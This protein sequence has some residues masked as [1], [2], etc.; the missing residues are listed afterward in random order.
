MLNKV[1]VTG[2]QGFCGRYICA[3]IL[4]YLPDIEILGIGRSEELEHVFTH[5]I[6]VR[7]QE[8]TP[9]PLTEDLLESLNN[10]RYRYCK[11]D[12]SDIPAITEVLTTFKPDIIIHLAS[13]LKGDSIRKLYSTN[14]DGTTTLLNLYKQ[15]LNSFSI[16]ALSSG[17]VY[18]FP[19]K[20]E[21]LPFTETSDMNP[22][23]SYQ[24]AKS[25]EE[26]IV[27][28][29]TNLSGIPCAILRVFNIV[30]PGQDERHVLGRFT[31]L[32]SRIKNGWM[33]PTIET[34]GLNSSRDFID[35]RDIA[36]AITHL[37]KTNQINGTYNVCS[38]KPLVITDLLS[39]CIKLT[40]KTAECSITFTSPSSSLLKNPIEIDHHVGCNRKIKNT[41]V[42]IDHDITSSIKDMVC[43]YDCVN[44]KN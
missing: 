42:E 4:K 38:G 1:L 44:T 36:K 11:A 7:N 25:A 19:A 40:F 31:S 39:E 23:D 3:S 2:A 37:I 17:G 13:G 26:T 24:F 35:V 14:I 15:H 30:G 43:Y 21:D 16:I 8:L 22:N 33:E 28:N 18:G 9:A 12:I 27:R 10:P 34:A 29:F 20:F 41:G 32:L 5:S 6:L